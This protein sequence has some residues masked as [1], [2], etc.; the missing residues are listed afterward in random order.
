MLRGVGLKGGADAPKDQGFIGRVAAFCN[1]RFFLVGAAVVIYAAK[2][3]PSVGATGGLLHPEITVNKAGK[4]R[5]GYG[6]SQNGH[7]AKILCSCRPLGRLVVD[8]SHDIPM[9][10]LRLS[11]CF[12]RVE[13]RYMV[14]FHDSYQPVI[15]RG[16]IL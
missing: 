10:L 13:R 1:K 14:S 3:A 2:L 7:F 15:E 5:E 6:D 4:D 9:S 16:A 8:P 12:L 11:Y